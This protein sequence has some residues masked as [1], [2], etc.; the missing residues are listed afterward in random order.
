MIGLGVG[1]YAPTPFHHENSHSMAGK[2]EMPSEDY[3]PDTGEDTAPTAPSDSGPDA[4]AGSDAAESDSF[5]VPKSA[6]QGQELKPGDEFIFKV[7][8]DHGEE[9]E[10]EYSKGE[11]KDDE[12]AE[13]P[14]MG[15]SMQ[16]MDKMASMAE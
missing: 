8:K 6:F 4:A 9:V 10:V 2:A 11:G 7:V 14:T 13:K 3:M 16:G 15:E 5:L 12:Y 1:V